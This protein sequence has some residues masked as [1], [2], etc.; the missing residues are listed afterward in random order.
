[1]T[2]F[3]FLAL[4]LL[5]P[6]TL[7]LV[8]TRRVLRRQHVGALV[9]LMV[10]AFV[11]TTPWDN[12]LVIRGVWSFDTDK[13]INRF[14]WRVPL[15]EYLFYLLQVAMSGLFTIW[16]LVRHAARHHPQG[17]QSESGE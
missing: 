9:L 13:I 15:E 2:Y 12:Y 8:L 3:G 17:A 10:I 6:I 5:P 14:L 1:M 11:Y 4:F 7:L 16:L